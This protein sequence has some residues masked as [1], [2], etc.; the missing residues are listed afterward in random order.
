MACC[1]FNG[2]SFWRAYPMTQIFQ[3]EED[4]RGDETLSLKLGIKGTFL[5]ESTFDRYIFS[6]LLSIQ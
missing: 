2:F 3:H 4:K 1:S 5:V 6:F